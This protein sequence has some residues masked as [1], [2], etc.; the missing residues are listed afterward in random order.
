LPP[1][2]TVRTIAGGDLFEFGD[3]D[4]RGD[5][6][7]LQHPLGIAA[8]GGVLFIADTYNHKIRT[9]NPATGD[10]R[11]FAGTGEGGGADGPRATARFAEPGG[12]A[13]TERDLYVADTNNHSLRRVSLTTDRVETLP[14]VVPGRFEAVVKGR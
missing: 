2:N 1:A 4:G 6:A 12:L 7:R 13:A 3:R 9:L 10:V 11:S 8:A 14:V 5:T